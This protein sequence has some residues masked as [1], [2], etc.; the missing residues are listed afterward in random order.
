V[1]EYDRQAMVQVGAEASLAHAS[2]Q[3][4][5]SGG[6]EFDIHEVFSHRA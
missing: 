1:Q 6:D 2:V 4:R 3:I 5:L